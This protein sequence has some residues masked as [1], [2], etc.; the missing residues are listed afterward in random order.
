M[1]LAYAGRHAAGSAGLTAGLE[2]LDGLLVM[3][4]QIEHDIHPYQLKGFSQLRGDLGNDNFASW[5]LF[6]HLL[7]G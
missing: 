1:T 2:A 4:V 6:T 5:D 3:I 7:L